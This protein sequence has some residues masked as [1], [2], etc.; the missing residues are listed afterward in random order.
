M[1]WRLN[2]PDQEVF[3]KKQVAR[4]LAIEERTLDR[5]IASGHFPEGIRL[6]KRGPL[7][8]TGLDIAAFLYLQGRCREATDPP[9][10]EEDE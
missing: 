4:Y 1:E 3:D 2:G 10:G 6:G 9:E 8:W 5:L 7:R